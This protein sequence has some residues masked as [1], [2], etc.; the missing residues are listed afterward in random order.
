MAWPELSGRLSR[1]GLNGAPPSRFGRRRTVQKVAAGE[2]EHREMILDHA[3]DDPSRRDIPAGRGQVLDDGEL[4]GAM[5]LGACGHDVEL[6][7]DLLL[8][9]GERVG[10]PAEHDETVQLIAI[11]S[12]ARGIP[13][14]APLRPGV[15]RD[16]HFYTGAGICSIRD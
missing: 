3:Q 12:P 1:S 15:V 4:L 16:G 7:E 13:E 8:P 14:K 2:A 5:L 6:G 11:G 9:S 10:W